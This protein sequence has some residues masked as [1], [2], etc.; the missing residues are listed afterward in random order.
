[1]GSNPR[2]HSRYS[3][4]VPGY[5]SQVPSLCSKSGIAFCIN[6]TVAGSKKVG[7]MFCKMG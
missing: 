6:T 4:Q 7:S 5:S 3:S 2:C 1:M